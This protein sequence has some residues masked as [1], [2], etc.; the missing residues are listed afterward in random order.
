MTA[1]NTKTLK[2]NASTLLADVTSSA[3][4]GAQA[5]V[6]IID[7]IKAAGRL[8][9]ETVRD[10]FVSGWTAGI[11]NRGKDLTPAMLVAATAKADK[12]TPLFTAQAA[13]RKQWSRMLAKAGAKTTATQ[14]G[15]RK[16]KVSTANEAKP[17]TATPAASVERKATTPRLKTRA[18]ATEWLAAWEAQGLAF[19]NK[20]GDHVDTKIAELVQALAKRIAE[21][22]AQD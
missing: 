4:R 16:P 3:Y 14:G 13:A 11:M 1:K 22:K 2:V 19:I 20:N 15:A 7:A 8:N 21:V 17:E 6:A 10:S 9:Q 5:H 12:G 18:G